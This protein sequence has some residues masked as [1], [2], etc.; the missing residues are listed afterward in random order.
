MN[1]H[2][3]RDLLGSLSDYVD[4]TAQEALCAEI[5]RHLAEC[6]DCRVVVD[7]LK[8]TI[9]LV[10]T[11]DTPQ[12]ALPEEVRTRLFRKLNLEDYLSHK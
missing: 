11:L 2:Q 7:T 10:H 4:G 1:A 8:K 5:E 6:E 9:Y 3:C 12:D